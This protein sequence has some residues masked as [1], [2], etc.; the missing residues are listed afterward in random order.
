LA[1]NPRSVK[2]SVAATTLPPPVARLCRRL[3]GVF[4]DDA[5]DAAPTY[6]HANVWGGFVFR[7]EWL[8]RDD[9]G[10]GLIGITITHRV[11]MP[12]RLMRGVA[13]LALSRRQAEVCV[14]L[15]AGAMIDTIAER[16]GISRHTANEHARWIYNK[17]DVHSRAELVTRLLASPPADP[18]SQG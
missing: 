8:E 10:P 2:R 14:L 6:C 17:L 4:A 5:V 18:A 13:G 7:A 12:I 9:T 11:P 16:L 1:T 3:S 15:A